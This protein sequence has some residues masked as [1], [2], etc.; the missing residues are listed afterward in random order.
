[1]GCSIDN[2]MSPFFRQYVAKAI[3][4][5]REI[6]CEK[7]GKLDGLEFHHTKYSPDHNVSINDIQILCSSCHRSGSPA[8]SNLRTE[9]VN[10]KRFCCVGNYRFE[11]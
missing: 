8:N 3:S 7:C 2:W 1:M 10:E 4:K 5:T 11:Y 6:K 9:F